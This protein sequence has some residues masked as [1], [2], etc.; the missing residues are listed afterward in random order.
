VRAWGFDVGPRLERGVRPQCGDADTTA[1]DLMR[2]IGRYTEACDDLG[3]GLFKQTA[4]ETDAKHGKAAFLHGQILAEVYRL[5]VE[6][7]KSDRRAIVF[8]D[9]V[10]SQVVAMQAA[11]L[12]GHLKTPAHGLQWI[13]N[14]LT[15]PGHLPY[16][17]AA[18]ALGGAQAWWDRE[19][20]KH[21]EFRRE[22]PGPATLGPNVRAKRATTAGRQ[23]RATENVHRTCGPG[24]VACRWRSA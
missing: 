16:L 22:H 17:E 1:D 8:G 2:L 3:A 12:E 4:A 10:H 7:N 19:T 14:T 13:V 21:E 15:G 18:R 9:I 6:A 24:L 20:A 11:V 5:H 23:A